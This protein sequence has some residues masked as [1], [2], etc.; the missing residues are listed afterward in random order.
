MQFEFTHFKWSCVPV[1]QKIANQIAIFT[2]FFGSGS[3]RDT[4]SL[5]NGIIRPHVIDNPNEA[6][7][8]YRKFDPENIVKIGATW[9]GQIRLI[10]FH[11]LLLDCQYQSCI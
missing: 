4:G 3:I 7:I 9:P 11:S 8:Q 2:D 5:H 1:S 10:V 6:V